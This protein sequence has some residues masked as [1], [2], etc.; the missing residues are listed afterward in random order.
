MEETDHHGD[1]R[2]GLIEVGLRRVA[3]EGTEG[4]SRRDAARSL[5]VVANA[6]DRHFA[7]KSALLTAI[8]AHGFEMLSAPMAAALAALEA[9]QP[10]QAA[11]AEQ[12]RARRG[13]MWAV[14]SGGP[15][16]F[17][18][19][20]AS[21]DCAR[22]AMCRRRPDRFRRVRCLA[23]FW[24]GLLPRGI[25]RKRRAASRRRAGE[26]PGDG[27]RRWHVGAGS[28]GRA[29]CRRSP[30]PR[31]GAAHGFAPR[32]SDRRSGP[33]SPMAPRKPREARD[34]NAVSSPM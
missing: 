17:A 14:P 9:S 7:D 33:L 19:C 16:F 29:G 23:A 20:L 25:G 12:L 2:N 27:P 15:S 5:G 30:R 21:T 22:S 31:A 3:L 8:A 13:S 11:T 26:R 28:A 4:F 34:R 1:L 6:A 18:R 32:G 24:T 10:A